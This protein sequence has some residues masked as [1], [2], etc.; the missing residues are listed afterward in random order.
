MSEAFDLGRVQ[1]SLQGIPE[2]LTP[3]LISTLSRNVD[4][5]QSG[6]EPYRIFLGKKLRSLRNVHLRLSKKRMADFLGLETV[7]ELEAYER[8][9][10]ELPRRDIEDIEDFFFLRKEFFESVGVAPFRTLYVYDKEVGVLL[11]QGFRVLFLCKPKP[12][13]G[14]Y[15]FPVLWKIERDYVRV[16][17]HIPHPDVAE[18]RNFG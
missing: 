7:S 1:I 4:G 2:N 3:V 8:G 13:D 16:I 10:K 18:K 14:L 9:E 17:T 12:R 15:T 6:D 5:L 11:D